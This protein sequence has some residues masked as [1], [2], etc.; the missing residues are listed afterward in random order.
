M[1][2]SVNDADHE[3]EEQNWKVGKQ[4]ISYI[5]YG[6]EFLL[7]NR[8]YCHCLWRWAILASDFGIVTGRLR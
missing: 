8:K 2:E 5:R 6:M 7:Q 4:E 3:K 1:T